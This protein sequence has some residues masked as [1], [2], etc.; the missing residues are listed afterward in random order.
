MLQAVNNGASNENSTIPTPKDISNISA[1]EPARQDNT[2]QAYTEKATKKIGTPD[3]STPKHV[4]KKARVSDSEK[5]DI[6]SEGFL[7]KYNAAKKATSEF[8]KEQRPFIDAVSENADNTGNVIL[9]SSATLGIVSA[10]TLDVPGEAIALVG[11]G[12]GLGLKSSSFAIDVAADFVE[13]W[14]NDDPN[15]FTHGAVNMVVNK[16]GGKLGVGADNVVK[17]M[18][19]GLTNMAQDAAGQA[20]DMV[21][22]PQKTKKK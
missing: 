14:A 13:A 22:P 17:G 16:L 21:A 7:E 9:A 12:V 4:P 8:M 1:V 5:A 2:R 20:V 10:A 19:E 3:I 18:A 6:A 15:K 11:V